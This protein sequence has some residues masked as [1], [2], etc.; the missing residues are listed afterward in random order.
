VNKIK[1]TYFFIFFF[2]LFVLSASIYANYRIKGSFY[3]KDKIITPSEEVRYLPIRYALVEV[4]DS[5][6]NYVLETGV[7]DSAGEFS[8]YIEE[9]YARDIR[10]RCITSMELWDQYLGIIRT[11]SEVRNIRKSELF[12]LTTEVY[13]NH[14]SDEDIDF[15]VTPVIAED[16]E[17]GGAFNIYDCSVNAVLYLRDLNGGFDEKV[18]IKWE[19]GASEGTGYSIY[20]ETVYLLGLDTDSD[21]YDDAVIIHEL[22]HFAAFKFARDDNPGVSHYFTGRY[23]LHISWSEGWANFFACEVRRYFNIESCN[24]YQ[25]TWREPGSSSYSIT[26]FEIEGPSHLDYAIG[27]E[28]ELSV[29]ALLWDITDDSATRDDS[30]GTD[31]D[32]MELEYAEQYIWEAFTDFKNS[33][34]PATLEL[35]WNNWN[36][37]KLQLPKTTELAEILKSRQIEYFYDNHE[38][39]NP[40][41]NA[42]LIKNLN[43]QQHHT[44]YAKNDTDWFKIP[45]RANQKIKIYTENLDNGADTY[46]QLYNKEDENFLLI[47]ENDDIYTGQF[48]SEIIFESNETDTIYISCFQDIYNLKRAFYGSYD[49]I[50]KNLTAPVSIVTDQDEKFPVEYRLYRNYPNPFNSQTVIKYDVREPGYLNISIYNILGQKVRTLYDDYVSKRGTFEVVWK[51]KNNRGH[52]VSS[53]IYI[54]MMKINSI[55]RFQRLTYLK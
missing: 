38:I 10:I 4:V 34:E 27:S 47:L 48:S 5:N 18:Q 30:E 41:K 42:N 55:R 3:Y 54:C 26:Q 25:D 33:N 53:G 23:G 6:N 14:P 19:E 22:G 46:L 45:V 31:D 52:Y 2:T 35:F 50:F 36:S 44:L 24:Y 9:T 39:D 51:G 11:V 7:T 28:N 29:A 1:L 40:V 20:E 13:E 43:L 32:P 16:E 37:D 15:I 17:I 49:I 21:A 8:I 12:A